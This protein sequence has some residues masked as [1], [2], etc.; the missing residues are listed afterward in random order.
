MFPEEISTDLA[1]L[2][3]NYKRNVITCWID[4][5]TGISTFESHDIVV[6]K[7]LTYDD[8]ETLIRCDHKTLTKLWHESKKLG[9][10]FNMEVTDTHKMVEV[11]MIYYNQAMANYLA[12]NGCP[13]IY[14]SQVLHER[15][16]YSLKQQ[17][18]EQL[19]LTHYTHATS[20]IRR[21]VDVLIQK[22]FKNIDE[23]IDNLD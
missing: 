23:N 9:K 22:L 12:K 6:T 14:R 1:S 8:A 3:E 17:L 2:I 18:H 7:N 15:A 16:F 4:L 10:Q 5:D 13:V 20:P 21:Y 19:N 11:Y